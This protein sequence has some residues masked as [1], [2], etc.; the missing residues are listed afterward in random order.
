MLRNERSQSLAERLRLARLDLEA[1]AGGSRKAP[2]TVTMAIIIVVGLTLPW[3]QPR[4]G[5]S[6]PYSPG[7]KGADH[8]S[9]PKRSGTEAREKHDKVSNGRDSMTIRA[10][11]SPR[12][13]RV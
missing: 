3:A 13:D 12:T 5:R 8:K 6:M 9:Q 4:T 10:F 11:F 2:I 7:T 1:G